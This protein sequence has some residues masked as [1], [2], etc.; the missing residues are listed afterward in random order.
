[1]PFSFVSS[2]LFAAFNKAYG[3]SGDV[4][5]YFVYDVISAYSTYESF[6]S[7]VQEKKIETSLKSYGWHFVGLSCK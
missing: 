5:F 7:P 4:F 1:L 6:N 2:V 3:N